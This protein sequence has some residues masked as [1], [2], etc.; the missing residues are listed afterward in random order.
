[1]GNECE[2]WKN[3]VGSGTPHISEPEQTSDVRS[4]C[5]GS[6]AEIRVHVNTAGGGG[7]GGGEEEE[8]DVSSC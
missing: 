4:A 8:K 7:G 2:K 6:L 1:M 3:E 5:H